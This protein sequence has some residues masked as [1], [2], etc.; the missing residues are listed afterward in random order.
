MRPGETVRKIIHMIFSLLLS[1][2][3]M[4]SGFIDPGIIYGVI[5]A[6]GG[7]VYSVQ[8]KG[9]PSWLRA[10][11]QLPQM[12]QIESVIES[13][14]KLINMVERDYERR[15]GWLGLIS[16]LIGGTSSYFI[17]GRHVIYGLLGLAL[18]DGI[19]T[20]VGMNMGIKKIP[21]SDKTI[22]GTVSGFLSFLVVLSLLTSDLTGSLMVAIFSSLTELYGIEDNITVPIVA[23]ASSY[24]IGMP[25]LL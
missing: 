16:G 22:E 24:L 4:L 1:V 19:S 25:I 5:L 11:M 18:V 8:V 13:F 15:S 14:E 9:I 20:I 23:S 12:R 21:F 6:I 7:T 3:L 10:G 17:F 2:P